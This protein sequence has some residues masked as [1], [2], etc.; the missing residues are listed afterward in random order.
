MTGLLGPLLAVA[1][2]FG[3]FAFMFRGT[4]GRVGRPPSGVMT[5]QRSPGDTRWVA[6]AMGGLA[7]G[8]AL[9]AYFHADTVTGVVVGGLLGVLLV[10]PMLEIFT[11]LALNAIAF[12]LSLVAAAVFIAGAGGFDALSSAYRILVIV[13]ILAAFGVGVFVSGGYRAALRGDR[14]LE[15]FGIVEVATFLAAPSGR[16]AMSLGV[17]TNATYLPIAAGVAA[18]IG[19]AASEYVLG[20]LALAIVLT[21]W[22]R[23]SVFGDAYAGW[24]GIVTAVAS[25]GTVLVLSKVFRLSGRSGAPAD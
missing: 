17:L 9:G 12:V 20:V 6:A 4:R 14:G 23:E 22:F 25:V 3:I 24:A 16:D 2:L 21:V 15:L 10:I 7:I 13:S 5:R 11:R 19:W 1:F 8:S 18:L